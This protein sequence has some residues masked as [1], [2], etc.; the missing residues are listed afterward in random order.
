MPDP[1]PSRDRTSRRVERN[2]ADPING[3][4]ERRLIAKRLRSVIDHHVP[5]D[6][7][8]VH[9]S[10]DLEGIVM[11]VGHVVVVVVD[12]YR[13]AVPILL[14]RI[15]RTIDGSGSVRV[16]IR[17]RIDAIV[18]IRHIVVRD[19]VPG[20]VHLHGDVRCHLRRK[21]LPFHAGELRPE[22]SGPADH[23]L[24]IVSS[25]EI[26]VG[27]VEVIGAGIIRVDTHA[28]V[29]KPATLHGQSLGS[30]D[31]LR[32]GPDGDFGVPDG[33]ALEIGIVPCLHVEEIERPVAIEDRFTIARRLDR[34]GLL[35]CS[36]GR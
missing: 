30:L 24:G 13:P 6:P 11:E 29:F 3:P 10:V 21:H 1:P 31:E 7:D 9:A 5:H 15:L 4:A 17:F 35:R 33:E 28:D 12:G 26:V 22:I 36:T 23:V 25:Y 19:D 18:E 27:D 2:I 34:D 32:T 14:G 8:V 20:A 16:A